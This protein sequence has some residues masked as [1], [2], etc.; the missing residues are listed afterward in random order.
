MLPAE[1]AGSAANCAASG[2]DTSDVTCAVSGTDSFALIRAALGADSSVFVGPSPSPAQVPKRPPTSAPPFAPRVSLPVGS[3]QDANCTIVKTRLETRSTFNGPPCHLHSCQRATQGGRLR[4][5]QRHQRRLRRQYLR[6]HL[7]HRPRLAR[8]YLSLQTKVVASSGRNDRKKSSMSTDLI[9]DYCPP[10]KG[11]RCDS[12]QS[13]TARGNPF[14]PVTRAA[15]LR[16]LNKS[17]Q[18][19]K[20]PHSLY[21]PNQ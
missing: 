10:Q 4:R 17:R 8:H 11:P 14:Y 13:A 7:H 2:A 5:Q 19:R 21:K 1:S 9:T 15:M 6:A 18:P 20:K 16:R 3:N 12:V